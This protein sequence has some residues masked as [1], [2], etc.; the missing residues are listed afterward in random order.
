MVYGYV[1]REEEEE[2]DGDE[3]GR[4]DADEAAHREGVKPWRHELA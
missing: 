3:G 4:A 1:R 2:L